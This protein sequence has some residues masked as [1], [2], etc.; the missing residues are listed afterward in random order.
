[1]DDVIE[2]APPEPLTRRL[3]KGWGPRAAFESLLIVFSVVLALTLADWAEDRKTAERVREARAYLVAEIS[4]NRALLAGDAFLPH[5]RRLGERFSEAGQLERPTAQQAMPAF[6]ALFET[7]IHVAPLR[8]SV[9]RSTSSRGLTAEM[10]LTE[11]FILSDIYRQQ[12][13]MSRISEA[14]VGNMPA[15][16]SGVE[17]GSG[18]KTALTAVTLHLGD[19]TASETDLIRRYD[20]ALERLD[21]TGR[22]RRESATPRPGDGGAATR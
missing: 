18:V 9:W 3:W 1:M 17:D 7:G 20:A 13:Q 16:L 6:R 5:H 4:T 15:L 14:F 2:P 8:D 10:P 11:V 12:E 19:I 21:P 22:L